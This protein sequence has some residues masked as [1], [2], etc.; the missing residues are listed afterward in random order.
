MVESVENIAPAVAAVAEAAPVVAP[1][2]SQ[3][4]LCSKRLLKVLRQEPFKCT[5]CLKTAMNEEKSKHSGPLK[6]CAGCDGYLSRGRQEN[7]KCPACESGLSRNQYYYRLNGK[8]AGNCTGCGTRLLAGK[9]VGKICRYCVMGL[10][11][12]LVMKEYVS[13]SNA[14]RRKGLELS[15]E[16]KYQAVGENLKSHKVAPVSAE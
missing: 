9:S 4:R 14:A 3:C 10:D 5:T 13:I 6:T 15:V 8:L 16:Q 1:I 12:E 2:I 7:G 11:R